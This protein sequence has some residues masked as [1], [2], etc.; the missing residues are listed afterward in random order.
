VTRTTTSNATLAA[1]LAAAGPGDYITLNGT[2]SGSFNVGA[3][4]TQTNPIV[5]TALT[6]TTTS[7]G[8]LNTTSATMSGVS[9]AV[10]GSWIVFKDLSFTGANNGQF[11]AV[12][13]SQRCRV[14]RCAFTDCGTG[15]GTGSQVITGYSLI[16]LQSSGTPG[17][18]DPSGGVYGFNPPMRDRYWRVEL[19]R[20][21]RPRTT[22][23]Y[24]DH[25]SVGNVVGHCLFDDNSLIQRQDQE[26]IKVGYGFGQDTS[27]FYLQ[28]CTIRNWTSWP[29]VVGIKN[30]GSRLVYN[31]LESTNGTNNN[32]CIRHGNQST[33]AGNSVIGADA[34]IFFGGDRNIVRA[35]Y[36]RR[37][38]AA[39]APWG[40]LVVFPAGTNRDILN[41]SG[42][43]PYYY[44]P[45][46]NSE[47]S[48]NVVYTSVA[49]GASVQ[50]WSYYADFGAGGLPNA[51]T[52]TG[53]KFVRTGDP[54]N[55]IDD[56]A[57]GLASTL[58]ARQTWSNNTFYAGGG[59]SAFG[60]IGVNGNVN[61]NPGIDTTTT[62]PTVAYDSSL[63]DF[64]L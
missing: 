59:E 51:N 4:G 28:F 44:L 42:G 20:F 29:Y 5:V 40:P 30:S 37:T 2:Y 6:S 13:P 58:A 61:T 41:G 56:I 25:G 50:A 38:S 8:L 11:T 64:T 19:C 63:A 43:N 21:L 9:F 31:K 36:I 62:D 48:D 17:S 53:N 54:A 10:T 14:Y 32:L 47:V 7:E 34:A 27:N 49:T 39:G 26:A 15:P 55:F 3:I 12:D 18:W 23:I 22:P 24:S 45:C 52:F 33:I 57:S 1:A 46:T 35:N 16:E 60:L